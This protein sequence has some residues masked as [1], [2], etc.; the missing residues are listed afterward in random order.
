MAFVK[1]K[2]PEIAFCPECGGEATKI[3]N[4]ITCIKC[5]A[6]S[7][8]DKKSERKIKQID[9]ERFDQLEQ[10]VFAL[11]LKSQAEPKPEPAIVYDEEE[12]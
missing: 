12:D 9:P 6:I 4:E 1:K 5:N 3:G 2:S 8:F 10:V 7:T 11:K